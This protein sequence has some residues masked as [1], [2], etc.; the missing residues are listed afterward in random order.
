MWTIII[1]DTSNSSYIIFFDDLGY[2]MGKQ[3]EMRPR[4]W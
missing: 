2:E 3:A 4:V 1:V